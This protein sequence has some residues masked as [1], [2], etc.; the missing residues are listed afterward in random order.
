MRKVISIIDSI[1]EKTGALSSWLVIVLIVVILIE[2][3]AR[4]VFNTPTSWAFDSMRLIGG[5]II[6]LGWA[7]AQ[8]YDSHIRVDIF[9]TCLSTRG[10]ALIDILG[11]V[12]FFFPLFGA[13]T[14]L[15]ISQT[16][17]ELLKTN[18][19]L[20]L[21]SWYSPS[22]LYGVVFIIGLCLTCLQ[23]AAQLA[24]DIYTLVK[25]KYND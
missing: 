18:Q 21:Q 5:A 12:L 3:I 1:N 25:G 8:L 17:K 6:V 19:L 14:W 20:P 15:V 24:R 23:F 2:V 9:Y 16:I 11:S 10:K 4:Y 22:S 7:Y 13:L